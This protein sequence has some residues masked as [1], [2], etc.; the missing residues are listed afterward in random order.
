MLFA[1][2]AMLKKTTTIRSPLEILLIL[3]VA[4]YAVAEMYQVSIC[5][6]Y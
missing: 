2:I 1:Y 3:T 4:G 6:K 5:I